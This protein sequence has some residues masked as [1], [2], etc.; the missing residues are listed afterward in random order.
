MYTG[1]RHLNQVL[2]VVIKYRTYLERDAPAGELFQPIYFNHSSM[3]VTIKLL[4]TQENN[5]DIDADTGQISTC[6]E[7][8]LTMTHKNILHNTL[9]HCAQLCYIE[10]AFI[11]LNLVNNDALKR[12]TRPFMM[13]QNILAQAFRLSPEC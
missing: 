10:S 3:E 6:V 1:L 5:C 11:N 9:T 12:I 13:S 4:Q 8:L 2:H 7:I